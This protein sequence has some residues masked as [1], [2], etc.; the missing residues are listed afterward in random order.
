MSGD[1]R[2]DESCNMNQWWVNK[3]VS[4]QAEKGERGGN[5]TYETVI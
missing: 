1:E 5:G 4:R 2:A 3:R